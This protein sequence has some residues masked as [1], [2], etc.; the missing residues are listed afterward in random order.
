MNRS[1]GTGICLNDFIWRNPESGFPIR[2]FQ[3]GNCQF[4]VRTL[5]FEVRI[6]FQEFQI[7]EKLSNVRMRLGFVKISFVPDFLLGRYIKL[8]ANFHIGDV[9]SLNM[10]IDSFENLRV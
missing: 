2:H 9:T 8:G 5:K 3:L 7:A 6:K 1:G 4:A 10:Q